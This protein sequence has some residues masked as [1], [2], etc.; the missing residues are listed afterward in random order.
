MSN[1]SCDAR[2]AELSPAGRDLLPDARAVIARTEEMKTRARSVVEDGVPQLSIAVDVYFPRR[3][4]IACLQTL[5]RKM[6]TAVVS[7]RMAA[8]RNFWAPTTNDALSISR[9][10]SGTSPAIS[11]LPSRSSAEDSQSWQ[12]YSTDA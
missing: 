11:H 3:H 8:T 10:R 4:L 9:P 1:F 6:P 2:K 12:A 5:H 7:L